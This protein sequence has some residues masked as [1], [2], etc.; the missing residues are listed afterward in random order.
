MKTY[1]ARP[2][3]VVRQWRLLDADGQILGRLAVQ[4]AT[5]LRGKH[6]ATWTPHIDTGDGVVVV[7]AAKVRV[8]G[9]KMTQKM[10]K[11]FSGYP[12]G[13]KL[14]SLEHLLARRP[15]EVFRH[16]VAGM[17]PKNP[18]GRQMLRRLRIYPGA[19]HPHQGLT[20]QHAGVNHA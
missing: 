14:E 15:T 10:Y 5:W 2:A 19:D 18:L 4:A 16:A 11:R 20:I 6:K 3:E 7:N 8:T 9:A 1:M 12:G 13:L 17:L